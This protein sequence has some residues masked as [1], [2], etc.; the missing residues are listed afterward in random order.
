MKLAAVRSAEEL[1]DQ[2]ARFIDLYVRSQDLGAVAEQLGIEVLE[3]RALFVRLRSRIIE[4]MMRQEIP[5]AQVAALA[6]ATLADAM[7]APGV[8]QKDRVSAA[9]TA[10]D[11]INRG[12]LAE[13]KDPA[14]A[15]DAEQFDDAVAA[16]LGEK[17]V[18]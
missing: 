15:G 4:R 9:K 16:V 14:E 3:A 17:K 1:T 11:S 12:R 7:T 6:K 10:L 2:E 13:I 18:N 8:S 5:W